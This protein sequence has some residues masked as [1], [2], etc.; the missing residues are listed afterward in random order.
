M[1]L[2]VLWFMIMSKCVFC[3][4]MAQCKNIKSKTNGCSRASLLG[5]TIDETLIYLI[6]A[7]S[8]TFAQKLNL[9]HKDSGQRHRLEGHRRGSNSSTDRKHH[10]RAHSNDLTSKRQNELVSIK[11]P[12]FRQLPIQGNGSEF[13]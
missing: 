13:N 9:L 4:D 12:L 6:C 11:F 7:L 10:K 5:P 2:S 8:S 3:G 1:N